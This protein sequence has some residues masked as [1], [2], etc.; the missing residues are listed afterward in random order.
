MFGGSLY[1]QNGPWKLFVKFAL[2]VFGEKLI[3]LSIATGH[4]TAFRFPKITTNVISD[5]RPKVKQQTT[6]ALGRNKLLKTN[7]IRKFNFQ[8]PC[9][10]MFLKTCV[11]VTKTAIYCD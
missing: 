7:F 8:V 9:D 1:T 4:A 5:E 6:C 11:Q 10:R 3:L 2:T